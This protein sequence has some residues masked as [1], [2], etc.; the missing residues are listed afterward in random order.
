M[1]DHPPAFNQLRSK[2]GVGSSAEKEWGQKVASS[3]R[4]IIYSA[5]RGVQ[6]PGGNLD[7]LL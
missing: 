5:Y 2:R 1:H 3:L 7:K 6:M 4:R